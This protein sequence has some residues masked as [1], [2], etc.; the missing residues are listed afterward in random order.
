MGDHFRASIAQV[1]MSRVYSYGW[2]VAPA[3][4]A[5]RIGCLANEGIRFAIGRDQIQDYQVRKGLTLEEVERWLGPY[6]NYQPSS[7]VATK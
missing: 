4:F 2:F 7:A 6:L 1:R 5:T 3:T